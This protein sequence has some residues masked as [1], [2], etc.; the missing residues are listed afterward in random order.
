MPAIETGHLRGV[1]G[2]FG[3][4]EEPEVSR[5]EHPGQRVHVHEGG[6]AIVGS[7]NSPSPG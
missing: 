5:A 1:E 3:R 2:T 6:Q 4:R 7:V